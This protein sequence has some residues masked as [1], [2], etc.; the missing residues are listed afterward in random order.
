[1]PENSAH[2]AMMAQFERSL[3]FEI[4][5][6]HRGLDDT[7]SVMRKTNAAE[8]A[9]LAGSFLNPEKIVIKTENSSDL[10]QLELFPAQKERNNE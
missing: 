10:K 9:S 7:H 3:Q 2:A 4:G 6:V 5:N 8:F 1:M